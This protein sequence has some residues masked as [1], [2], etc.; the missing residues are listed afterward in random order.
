[1]ASSAPCH[2]M[3]VVL[4]TAKKILHD[5]AAPSHS[6]A[7]LIS[8]TAAIALRV[9]IILIPYS[10]GSSFIFCHSLAT[11]SPKESITIS[12]SIFVAPCL[13]KLKFSVVHVQNGL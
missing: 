2:S 6:V 1:M 4:L 9:A 10:N 11:L 5:A 12:S 13:Y 3:L 7:A 8:M